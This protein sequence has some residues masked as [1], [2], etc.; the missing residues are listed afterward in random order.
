MDSPKTPEQKEIL[1]EPDTEERSH[2]FWHFDHRSP[3]ESMA[4][5]AA[6]HGIDEKTGR[7]WRQDRAQ[8]G[9]ARRVRKRKAAEKGHKLGRKFRVAE[10]QL[11]KLLHNDTNPVRDAPLEVQQRDNDMPLCPRAL[12]YNLSNRLNAHIYV[13]AYSNKVSTTNKSL[14]VQYGHSYKDE[15]VKGF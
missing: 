1:K 7:R 14:R 2:Y 4:A 10:D 15:D 8:F 6:A 9:D 11:E 5:V 13:A 3:G 12:R